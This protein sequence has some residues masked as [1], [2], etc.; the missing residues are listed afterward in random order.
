LLEI[1]PVLNHRG[2][3]Y[4]VPWYAGE[5][6]AHVRLKIAVAVH[7]LAW[8]YPWRKIHWE[9]RPRGAPR[10]TRPDLI[11]ERHRE[12]PAFWF[13]C[14]TT[15]DKKLRR[16][17]KKLQGVRIVNVMEM[18]WFLPWWNAE[19]ALSPRIKDTAGRKR[20]VLRERRRASVHGVEYWAI[21]E[22]SRS[23]RILYAVRR[24]RNGQF[25]YL[26]SG[27]GWSLSAIQFVSRRRDRFQAIIPGAVGHKK[28]KGQNPSLM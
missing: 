9:E 6:W 15:D 1:N 20:A 12:L 28:W 21:H 3:R 8:G 27:K 16:L 25:T 10:G 14:R 24:E 7:L 19:R 18:D 23:A 5:G 17:V 4:P 26:D 11:P 13:E 2:R 22:G